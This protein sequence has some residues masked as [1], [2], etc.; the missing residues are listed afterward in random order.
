[1]FLERP[2]DS[3]EGGE[4]R[5]D[6]FAVHC[7][8]V[9]NLLA[10]SFTLTTCLSTECAPRDMTCDPLAAHILHN[11]DDEETNARVAAPLFNIP[12]GIYGSAQSITVSTSTMGATIQYT[13]DGS[14]P[15][16]SNTAI[17]GPSGSS[18]ATVL[19]D[20]NMTLK[21]YAHLADMQDSI[22]ASETYTLQ[23]ANSV[24]TPPGGIQTGAPMISI[25]NP[26]P[27]ASIY[28]TTDGSIPTTAS[29]LYGAP[30]PANLGLQIRAI[31]VQ[32]NWMDSPVVN[33]GEY[34]TNYRSVGS[35]G[36]GN[37]QMSSIRGLAAG[38]SYVY[39]AEGGNHRI[40][41]FDTS[42]VFQGWLANGSVGWQMAAAAPGAGSASGQ[43]NAPRG[44][45]TDGAG[46]L[47]VADT[48]NNRVQKFDA[49][50]NYLGGWSSSGPYDLAVDSAGNIFVTEYFGHRVH[51]YR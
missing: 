1:M 32:T 22:E 40:Q 25:S 50:G 14:N 6:I 41:R 34:L 48:N 23:T 30:L 39:A 17:E 18:T 13:T 46:N 35:G 5:G 10:A 42:G 4:N 21:A 16:S 49:A 7:A 19:V 12:A 8:I 51:V 43:F 26:T 27:G 37:G 11:I 44:V 28:Y 36:S 33:S 31:A 45:A 20:H 15:E 47:F 38:G 2:I 3:P 29:T 24:F 9:F